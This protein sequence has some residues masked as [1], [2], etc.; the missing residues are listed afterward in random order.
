[1]KTRHQ[2][3]GKYPILTKSEKL[4][5]GT[6]H[7]H[8]TEKFEVQFFYGNRSS[9]WKILN[10]AFDN[11][12]GDPITVEGIVNFLRSRKIAISDTILECLRKNQNALDSDLI[13]EKLN[14]GLIDQIRNSTINEILFTSGFGKNNA[15]KLFYVDILKQKITKK[16]REEKFV[17]L[18]PVHFGRPVLLKIL[19]SPSGSANIQLSRSKDYLDVKD[20]Y[21]GYKTPVKQFKVDLYKDIFKNTI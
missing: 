13:P 5:L 12:I 9:I 17:L 11:E 15:F 8:F 14:Y 20:N 19:V 2:F 10:E 21:V 3:V 7:P 6:I 4:I 16:I 18:D 1:M